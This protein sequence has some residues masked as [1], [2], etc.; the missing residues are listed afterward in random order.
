MSIP[1][2]E[3]RKERLARLRARKAAKDSRPGAGDSAKDADASAGASTAASSPGRAGEATGPET[4]APS[5]KRVRAALEETSSSS[6]TR[7]AG[8]T[9]TFRNY[10]P[11]GPILQRGHR[12]ADDPPSTTAGEKVDAALS[13]ATEPRDPEEPLVVRQKKIDWDLKRDIQPQMDI[14]ER[15]TRIATRELLRRQLAQEVKDGGIQ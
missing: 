3:A 5:R 4:G 12:G 13:Q 7:R 9:I 11:S 10:A 6:P 8:A 15:R 14:L 1:A 2:M